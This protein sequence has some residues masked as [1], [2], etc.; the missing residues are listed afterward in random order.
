MPGR[1]SFVQQSF[2]YFVLLHSVVFA[3]SS[4]NYITQVGQNK[5]SQDVEDNTFINFFYFSYFVLSE[6]IYYSDN[7][8]NTI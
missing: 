2:K 6:D 1:I 3:W 5:Q 4:T 8:I 7:T